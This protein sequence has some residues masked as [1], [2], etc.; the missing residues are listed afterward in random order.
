M[1][2]LEKDEQ[3]IKDIKLLEKRVDEITKTLMELFSALV[4]LTSYVDVLTNEI[5]LKIND[6]PNKE[7]LAKKVMVDI[8]DAADSIIN[9]GNWNSNSKNRSKTVD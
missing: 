3:L 5:E 6:F 4:G 8:K 1:E 7:E 9:T 2:P